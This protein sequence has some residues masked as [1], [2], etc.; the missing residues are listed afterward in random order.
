[1][2]PDAVATGLLAALV[3]ALVSVVVTL[4]KAK[5]EDDVRKEERDRADQ[6][7][8]EDHDRADA[9]RSSELERMEQSRAR[10]LKHEQVTRLYARGIVEATKLLE[11]LV[12]LQKDFDANPNRF[13]TYGHFNFDKVLTDRAMVQLRLVPHEDLRMLIKLSIGVISHVGILESAGEL[14]ASGYD[15][16]RA[17]LKKALDG[18]EAYLS[19]EEIDLRVIIDLGETNREISEAHKS[20]HGTA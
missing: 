15:L 9:E 20:M 13:A 10:E 14:K 6:L 8:R 4:V 11:I 5:R 3:S 18:I 19:E 17:V 2:I 12:E 16:Q 7:R 1:M